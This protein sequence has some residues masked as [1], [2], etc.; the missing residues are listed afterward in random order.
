VD[1]VISRLGAA[2]LAL[3]LPIAG[4]REEHAPRV[5]VDGRP[6]RAGPG[7][8]RGAVVAPV[9]TVRARA[10]GRSFARCVRFDARSYP[11]DTVIVERVGV[12]GRSIT[13]ATPGRRGLVACQTAGVLLERQLAPWCTRS[14]GLLRGGRLL[15]PRL[16]IG[17]RDAGGR[18]V[19][20]AWVVPL[21]AARWIGV[22]QGSYVELYEVAGRL[23]VRVSSAQHV[24]LLRSRATFDVTQYTAGGRRLRHERLLAR[25]AG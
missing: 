8:I 1:R 15:D 10:L 17:C 7:W 4:C 25:V 18:A 20:F 23:P 14:F 6:A 24:D 12:S 21:R 2:C 22:A 19:A 11:A 3:A 9:R 16:D 13:F 5:L